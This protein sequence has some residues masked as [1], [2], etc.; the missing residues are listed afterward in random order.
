MIGPIIIPAIFKFL[1]LLAL[2]RP[3]STSPIRNSFLASLDEMTAAIPW[4]KINFEFIIK[5]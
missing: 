4:V 2:K 3:P 1:A 5:N